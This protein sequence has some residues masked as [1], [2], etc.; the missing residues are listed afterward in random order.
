MV[1]FK[2]AEVLAQDRGRRSLGIAPSGTY[3]T[4][5][6]ADSA[7][8]EPTAKQQRPHQQPERYRPGADA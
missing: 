3:P 6:G 7:E 1:Y 2:R 8:A 5:A 4:P